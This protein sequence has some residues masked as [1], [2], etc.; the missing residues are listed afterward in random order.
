IHLLRGVVDPEGAPAGPRGAEPVR[1]CRAQTCRR[2]ASFRPTLLGVAP[3]AGPGVDQPGDR[4]RAPTPP[5]G[6]LGYTCHLP[7]TPRP[8]PPHHAGRRQPAARLPTGPVLPG[9]G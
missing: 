7:G 1:P 3:G 4:R 6:S 2:T 9:A 5:R 8:R